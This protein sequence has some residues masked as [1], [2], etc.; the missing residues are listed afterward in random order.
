MPAMNEEE[1]KEEGSQDLILVTSSTSKIYTYFFL[2]LY[3]DC[4]S[5]NDFTFSESTKDVNRKWEVYTIILW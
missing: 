1:E 2:S 5:R 3:P 4:S